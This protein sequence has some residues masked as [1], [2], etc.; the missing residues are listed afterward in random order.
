VSNYDGVPLRL[1]YLVL[2]PCLL[3]MSACGGGGGSGGGGQDSSVT[4]FRVATVSPA[5]GELFV[6]L[7]S[8]IRVTFSDPVYLG[9]IND[10]N[11]LLSEVTTGRS[12]TGAIRL[13]SANM[14]AILEPSERFLL[15]TLYRVRVLSSVRSIGGDV[16]ARDFESV[17]ST[18]VTENPPSPPPVPSPSEG[19]FRLVGSMSV[20]RSSHSSNRLVDGR[21]LVVGGFSVSTAVTD[22]AELFD[23]VSEEFSLASDKLAEARGF[24]TGTRLRDGTVLLTGGVSGSSLVETASAEVYDPSDGSFRSAGTMNNARAF[25]TATLLNDGRLLIAGGTVPTPSGTFSSRTAETYD[26]SSGQFASL[27][28]MA[29]YRASHTATLLRDGTVLLVGGNSSD[30]RAEIFDPSD[31]TFST[32]TYGIDKPRRGH[33]ASL[34]PDGEVLLVGGEGSAARTAELFSPATKRF[35]LTQNYPLRDRKDHTA[36]MTEDGFVLLAGGSRMEG[37]TIFFNNTTELYRHADERFLSSSPSMFYIRTRHRAT[38]LGDG[39]ILVTGGANLDWTR[40]E[41]SSAE[42]YEPTE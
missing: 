20:G 17:F 40:P 37:Q 39:R 31:D 23:P 15:N 2:L 6:S 34:L 16:L 42:V 13:E 22:T 10:G 4:G 29:V 5:D 28:D 24:H 19:R 26:P 32:L 12:V 25:H 7:D 14:V 33:S 18:A 35:L 41:L 21:I 38:D 8:H 36:V 1:A 27:P 11:F 9:T 3:A 30:L